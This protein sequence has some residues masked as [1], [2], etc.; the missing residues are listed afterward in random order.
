[1]DQLLPKGLDAVREYSVSCHGRRRMSPVW[2]V[3]TTASSLCSG[4][5]EALG[6]ET[7]RQPWTSN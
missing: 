5:E 6:G 4:T 2:P 1:M 7:S 3:R